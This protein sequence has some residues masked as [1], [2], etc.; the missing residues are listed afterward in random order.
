[1]MGF[2]EIREVRDREYNL[3]NDPN[4]RVGT[5]SSDFDPDKRIEKCEIVVDPNKRVPFD[6]DARVPKGG[7]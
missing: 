2:R 7:F 3:Y 5:M 1:M 6:P 4:K